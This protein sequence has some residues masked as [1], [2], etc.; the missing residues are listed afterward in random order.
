MYYVKGFIYKE[1][2]IHIKA[3][4]Y[5]EHPFWVG[6]FERT[7]KEGYACSRHIF[8]SE[9]SDPEIYDFV[10]N[11]FSELKFGEPKEFKL[12]IKR[13]NPKRIQREV[14]KEMEKAKS[15][16]P[17]TFAQDYMREELEKNK[18][19]RKKKSKKEKELFEEMLFE[20]KTLKRKEKRKG[21]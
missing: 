3:T 14:R 19:E 15:Q 8:G 13:K 5:L 12:E 2:M 20:K 21:H 17:S 4:I 18:K 6:L 1:I 10:L 16:K 9:P 11:H 7:D